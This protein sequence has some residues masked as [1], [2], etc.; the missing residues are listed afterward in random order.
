VTITREE[1]LI[2]ALA[3][4]L[5][6][7]RHVAV[8]VSSPIPAAA[9]L[10]AALQAGGAM[11]VSVLGSRGRQAWSDTGVEMFDCAAQGRLDAFFL[12]GGQIDGGANL[13]LVGI[14]PGGAGVRWPGSFG[15]A[16]L[17]FAVPRVILFR[18][19]HSRRVLVPKVDFVSAP[20]TSPPGVWRR[21]G[22]VALVTGLCRFDFESERGGFLLASIHP[23][24]TADEVR[25][26]TGFAY[27]EPATVPTTPDPD[28]AT[29]A[30]LRG[31]VTSRLALAYPRFAARLAHDDG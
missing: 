19:E 15:S 13:N 27:D 6:G 8:G 31:P 5:S 23:G 18:E 3:R 10:L 17:Y 4:A 7:V 29:L 12:G 9:A 24:H 30:L 26:S 2:A 21:G 11:R 25:A 22:P 14:G 28:A 16:F 20:G 1:R